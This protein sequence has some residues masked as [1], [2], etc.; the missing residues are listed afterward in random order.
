M[1]TVCPRIKIC[2]DLS[3]SARTSLKAE[4]QDLLLRLHLM[5]TNYSVVVACKNTGCNWSDLQH[6][7]TI[8]SDTE[9]DTKAQ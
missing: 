1:D 7:M 2:T 8:K 6:V 5:G 3:I 9:D 4:M